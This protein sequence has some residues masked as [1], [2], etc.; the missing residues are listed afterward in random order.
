MGVALNFGST[1]SNSDG[2]FAFV[3]ETELVAVALATR[4]EDPLRGEVPPACY[5]AGIGV[6][7]AA[8]DNSNTSVSIA[9][10]SW[11]SA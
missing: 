11:N 6:R 2:T 3:A 10:P 4:I 9:L 5:E 7:P 8:G 1:C